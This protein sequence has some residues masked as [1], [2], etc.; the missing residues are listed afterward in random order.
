[1]AVRDIL[2]MGH[3]TLRQRA[4]EVPEADFAATWLQ[5]LIQDLKDT[6]V[7][8]G[9]IGL[10]APQ[11]GES[12]RVAII[13]IKGDN[14]RYGRLDPVPLKIYLNPEIEVLDLN[15]QGF[16]EGCL[17]VPGLRGYVERPRHIRVKFQGLE[18]EL[19]VEEYRGFMAT[20]FQHEFD[21]LD[22]HLYLDRMT[23]MTRLFF[24]PEFVRFQTSMTA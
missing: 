5:D 14:D 12:H 24:E 16:F 1:M 17:S 18:N 23:D 15:L 11:I 10:A 20:V 13:H 8:S 22:G 3:P 7:A 21:H 9:G 4:R 2:R 6:L 19:L